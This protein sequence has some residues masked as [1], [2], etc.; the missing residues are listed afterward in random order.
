VS[1][2]CELWGATCVQSRCFWI[3]FCTFF[4]DFLDYGVIVKMELPPTRELNLEGWRGS[5]ITQILHF[6]KASFRISK[7]GALDAIF[8]G[9]PAKRDPQEH[10]RAAQIHQKSNK[11][12]VQNSLGFPLAARSFPEG[13]QGFK[14]WAKVIEN[15]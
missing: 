10:P 13:V 15:Q 11:N 9:F 8:C 7:K 14:R 5:E 1:H 3:T 12:G 6:L 2:F 4:G